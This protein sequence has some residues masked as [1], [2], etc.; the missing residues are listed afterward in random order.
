MKKRIR[1]VTICLVLCLAMAFGMCGCKK[2]GAGDTNE[3][4]ERIK[5]AAAER[6]NYEKTVAGKN[7]MRDYEVEF[8]SGRD[9]R[10]EKIPTGIFDSMVC[11]DA[12]KDGKTVFVFIGVLIDNNEAALSSVLK[13][14]SAYSSEIG[15]DLNY[16]T[17]DGVFVVCLG[18]DTD[19]IIT[20]AQLITVGAEKMSADQIFK[21]LSEKTGGQEK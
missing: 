21:Q 17:N 1:S 15:K 8:L 5:A 6:D 7:V 16:Y 18:E 20:K 2:A 19:D 14:F 13:D 3:M 11:F 9:E 4:V 12:A 10:L